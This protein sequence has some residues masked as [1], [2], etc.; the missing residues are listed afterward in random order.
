LS[1]KQ[2]EELMKEYYIKYAKENEELSEEM[3]AASTEAN[4]FLDEY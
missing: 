3:M 2:K 1:K 4:R